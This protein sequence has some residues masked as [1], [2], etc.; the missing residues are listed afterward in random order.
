[1]EQVFLQAV[2]KL[3]GGYADAADDS[4]VRLSHGLLAGDGLAVEALEQQEFAFQEE[5]CCC[6]SEFAHRLGCRFA[7][8]FCCLS[9]GLFMGGIGFFYT[10]IAL[11]LFCC[12]GCLHCFGLCCVVK[13]PRD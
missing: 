8:C 1:M 4:K 2:T 7:F 5:T 3:E 6:I 11:F 12:E 10:G 9:C 13:A